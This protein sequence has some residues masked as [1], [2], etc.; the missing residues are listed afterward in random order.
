MEQLNK[1]NT[2]NVR[3]DVIKEDG[4]AVIYSTWLSDEE[5]R[6]TTF[7]CIP[8][9]TLD[10]WILTEAADRFIKHQIAILGLVRRKVKSIK[11]VALLIVEKQLPAT[12]RS[13]QSHQNVKTFRHIETGRIEEATNIALFCRE[14]DIPYGAFKKMVQG[15]NKTSHGWEVA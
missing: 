1:Y 3:I 4:V 14:R 11:E 8:E 13:Y 10:T 9:E 12:G 7:L 2:D 6:T 5:L 15:R